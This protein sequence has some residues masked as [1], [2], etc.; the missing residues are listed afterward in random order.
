MSNFMYPYDSDIEANRADEEEYW[1]INRIHRE[2]KIFT[3]S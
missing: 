1:R 2:M 3:K